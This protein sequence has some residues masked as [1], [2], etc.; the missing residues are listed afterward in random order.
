MLQVA[1]AEQF[2]QSLELPYRVV[3][4]VSGE[5]NSAA[6]KKYDLEASFPASR[7]FRE[8]V[9]CSNCT[10]YQVRLLCRPFRKRPQT[11][12]TNTPKPG[13]FLLA[14]HNLRG[15]EFCLHCTD[16]QV[17]LRRWLQARP[18]WYC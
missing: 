2:Y 15:L 8:L 3:N 1:I 9:S 10:D 13:G 14:G 7:T 16:Q 6:A 5:L 4:I 12:Q 11:Q 18:F 17:G